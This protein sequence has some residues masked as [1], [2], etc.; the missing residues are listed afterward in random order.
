MIE[1]FHSLADRHSGAKS[2]TKDKRQ[3][4]QKSPQARQKSKK[5]QK[6]NFLLVRIKEYKGVAMVALPVKTLEKHCKATVTVKHFRVPDIFT[7]FLNTQLKPNNKRPPH[8]AGRE[9]GGGSF[10]VIHL[11]KSA[12]FKNIVK[13]FAP[14]VDVDGIYNIEYYLCQPGTSLPPHQDLLQKNGRGGGNIGQ[15]KQQYSFIYCH[16]GSKIV[17]TLPLSLNE[18]QVCSVFGI[19]KIQDRPSLTSELPQRVLS[20]KGSVVLEP[21]SVLFMTPGTW[22]YVVTVC[23]SLSLGWCVPE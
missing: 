21:Q 13:I 18:T 22:H 6:K 12:E 19:V 14:L 9:A 23:T 8:S 2:K 3:V 20:H 16:T 5:K 4:P 1:Q 10:E 11:C 17:L 7:Q 15:L